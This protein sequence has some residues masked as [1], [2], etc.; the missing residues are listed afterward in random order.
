MLINS[1]AGG[2]LPERE[3]ERAREQNSES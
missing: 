2:A 3:R 1:T